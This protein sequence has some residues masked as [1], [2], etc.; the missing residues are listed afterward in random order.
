VRISPLFKGTPRAVPDNKYEEMQD[1]RQLRF[2]LSTN[3]MN[4]FVH[5]S[6]S[7]SVWLVL[8]SIYNLPPWLCNE[9]KYMMMPVLISGPQQPG[10]NIDVYLRPLRDDMKKLWSL[11]T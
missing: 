4:P 10:I 9:R 3:G 1:P 8:L 7:H 2:A 11:G 5:M 6:N